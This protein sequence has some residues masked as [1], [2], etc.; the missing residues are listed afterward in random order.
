MMNSLCLSNYILNFSLTKKWRK[1]RRLIGSSWATLSKILQLEASV[2]WLDGEQL[3]AKPSKCQMSWGLS[4]WQWLTEWSATHVPI[5][6]STLLSPAAWYVLVRMVETQLIPVRYVRLTVHFA[7]WTVNES[8]N[9][10]KN[11]PHII[12]LFAGGFRR[13]SHVQWCASW[14]HFLW[15]DVRSH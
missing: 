2:W 13:T 15:T 3:K 8:K 9:K 1:P 7:T 5:T 10:W 4:M 11:E 14:N 6:T 12:A